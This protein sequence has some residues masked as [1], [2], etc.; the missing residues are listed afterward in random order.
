[1]NDDDF[2]AGKC[3]TFRKK[4]IMPNVKKHVAKWMERVE[5]FKNI[6]QVPDETIED[7][8]WAM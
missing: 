1:M 4:N 7:E 2:C 5:A 6:F 3:L 8:F